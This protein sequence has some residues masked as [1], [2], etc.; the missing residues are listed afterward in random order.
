M[1]FIPKYFKGDWNSICDVCGRKFKSSAL[2]QRWDG[3]MCCPDDWEIRQPQDFVRGVPDTQVA[4]WIRHEANDSFLPSVLSSWFGWLSSTTVSIAMNVHHVLTY[5][6]TSYLTRASTT[7][8]LLV[9]YAHST[10]AIATV[11]IS[12]LASIV[13][14]ISS[15]L[16]FRTLTASTASVLPSITVAP[17]RPSLTSNRALNSTAVNVKT[18]G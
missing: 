3:L 11:N 1:S 7:V 12:T 4:P 2:E 8:N 17:I 9:H 15:H 5:L 18:I 6:S 14:V 10:L 16:N 13:M